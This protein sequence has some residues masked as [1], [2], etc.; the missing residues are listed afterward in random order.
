MCPTWHGKS[1]QNWDYSM[2]NRYWLFFCVSEIKNHGALWLFQFLRALFCQFD[3]QVKCTHAQLMQMN[4]ETSRSGTHACFTEILVFMQSPQGHVTWPVVRSGHVGTI[5]M[6]R[7]LVCLFHENEIMTQLY[8][9]AGH[10]PCI[11]AKLVI[12]SIFLDYLVIASA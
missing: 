4:H 3:P 1:I 10:I 11:Y 7:Y 2:W 8:D 9:I 6:I 5:W 12:L